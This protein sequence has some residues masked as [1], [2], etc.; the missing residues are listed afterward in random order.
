[1][2]GYREYIEYAEKY[3]I[4]IDNVKDINWLLIP[5]TIL[6]WSAIES[7]VNN[8]LDD[9]GNLPEDL[10]E[11][12]ERALLLEQKIKFVDSGN[13]AGSFCLEGQDY[14]RLEDK[15]LFLVFKFSNQKKIDLKEKNIWSE[16][17]IFKDIRDDLIHPRRNVVVN[18][19]IEKVEKFISISKEVIK[20]LGSQVWEKEINF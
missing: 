18:L 5:A 19:S 20:L 7:F 17:K 10:F 9:F 3:L 6:A 8:M 4:E 16:F 1:M 13:K 15:I 12:H 11:L 2:T 14:R